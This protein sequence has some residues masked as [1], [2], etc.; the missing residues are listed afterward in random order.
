M[1]LRTPTFPPPEMSGAPAEQADRVGVLHAYDVELVTPM[2]G[3][4]TKAG[5]IDEAMP[6]RA[7]AIRGQLRMW[8]RLL[9][10]A[11]C[12]HDSRR[13][14]A[15][16]RAIWGGLGK[17]DSAV[18]SRV[19]LRVKSVGGTKRVAANALDSKFGY[20]IFPARQTQ[21]DFLASARFALE[22]RIRGEGAHAIWAE[23]VLPA[24]RWWASFGGLGARTRRGMGTVR[25]EAL[26]PVSD[27]EAGQHGCMLVS[28][29]ARGVALAAWEDVAERLK[30]FRQGINVGRNRGEKRPGRSRWPEPD[31]IR[32]ITGRFSERHKPVH[33]ARISF[34][35]AAFGL[36]IITDFRGGAGDPS[37]TEL[38]PLIRGQRKDRMASPLIVKAMWTGAGYAPIALLLPHAH[39]D[40]MGLDL[41]ALGRSSSLRCFPNGR[42]QWW[43]DSA[44]TAMTAADGAESPLKGRDPDVLIAFLQYFGKA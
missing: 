24:L 23:H 9:N 2:F 19:A 6:I 43:P 8:W 3:G 32:E 28:R 1:S 27:D 42:A 38:R 37:K 31:S 30:N 35:R 25:I 36:P 7:S 12:G 20:V 21:C 22:I 11:S 33:A 14:Y 10:A 15:A 34:P 26:P 17:A 4:G 5:H 40:V 44:R 29:P 16:E 18:A 39:V 13:L 41:I